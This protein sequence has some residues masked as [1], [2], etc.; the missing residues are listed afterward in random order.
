[1]PGNS[2]RIK[3]CGVTSPE[4]AVACCEAGANMI[5]IVH[6]PPSPRHLTDE[7]I[8]EIL[9]ALKTD[10]KFPKVDAVLVVVGQLPNKATVLRFDYIQ[11]YGKIPTDIPVKYIR[12]IKD[13][14][15]FHEVMNRPMSVPAPDGLEAEWPVADSSTAL[16][17]GRPTLGATDG[18][19]SPELYA[20]E[21]SSGSLPGGNGTPW[22]WTSAR[23]FCERFPTLI[24]GGVTPENVA[25]VIRLAKPA[26]IDV[27]SGVESAPGIKDIDKVKRLV[28]NILSLDYSLDE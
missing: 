18:L 5:G 13:E 22:D 1:M 23:P 17:I 19:Y 3:I 24:A 9:D 8:G 2:M 7:Q 10:E 4:T 16:P 25:E 14:T 20:L 15:A 6:Y 11:P 27:S 21:M 26:G 12:V 28:G